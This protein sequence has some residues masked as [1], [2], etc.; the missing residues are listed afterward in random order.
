MDM[1][2]E[3]AAPRVTVSLPDPPVMVSM[4]L[5]VAVLVALARVR[6]SLPA[7]RSMEPLETAAPRVM[8]SVPEPP[9]RVLVLLTVA[10]LPPAASGQFVDAG[11]EIDRHGVGQRGD[12]RDGV[13]A[14]AAGN[15]L[16]VG[17]RRGV[18]EV[19]EGESIVARAKIDG[20]RDCSSAHGNCIIACAANDGLGI[21]DGCG[22]AASGEGQRIE[23]R[24]EI[25][26]GVGHGIRQGG[27]VVTGRAEDG[28]AVDEQSDIDFDK[29]A[30]KLRKR[31]QAG[32]VEAPWIAH[33]N[34]GCAA[35]HGQ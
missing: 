16:G 3:T 2:L 14:C 4:L 29:S 32:L 19:A 27:I 6:V 18:G 21:G 15:G 11:A 23:P 17:D 8:A 9:I 33:L 5:T 7:P 28:V 12:Q 20:G 26:G 1:A 13:V 10:V 22:I 25:D 30:G 34:H 35:D 31:N 24:A